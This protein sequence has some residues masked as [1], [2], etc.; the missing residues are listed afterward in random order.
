MKNLKTQRRLE[1]FVRECKA[2]DDPVIAAVGAQNGCFIRNVGA[3]EYQLLL[4]ANLIY[5][6]RKQAGDQWDELKTD[7]FKI[8]DDMHEADK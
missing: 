3:P 1:K 7:L 2:N 5:A 8:V 6:F 4:L